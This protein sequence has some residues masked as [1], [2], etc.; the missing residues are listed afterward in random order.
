MDV[1]YL[2]VEQFDEI[3]P[4][5]WHWYK[6]LFHVTTADLVRVYYKDSAKY[7]K[8]FCR[9]RFA[10]EIIHNLDVMR[11]DLTC[12]NRY[13]HILIAMLNELEKRLDINAFLNTL[14]SFIPASTYGI[15]VFDDSGLNY[16]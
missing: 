11:L 5:E 3:I 7:G 4:M 2:N 6:M 15:A 8:E 16:L 10:K 1:V 12:G 9:D 14:E 13:G